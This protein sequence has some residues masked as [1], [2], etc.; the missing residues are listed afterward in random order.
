MDEEIKE[1]IDQQLEQAT[2]VLNLSN[3]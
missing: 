3:Y 2:S 1:I